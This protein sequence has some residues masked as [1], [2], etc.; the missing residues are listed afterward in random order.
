[1]ETLGISVDLGSLDAPQ[2]IFEAVGEREVGFVIYNAGLAY[3][4]AVFT[5]SSRKPQRLTAGAVVAF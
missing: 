2:K 5:F 1:V 3:V 4:I